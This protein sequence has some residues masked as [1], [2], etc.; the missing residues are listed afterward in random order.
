MRRSTTSWPKKAECG[1][2][3]PMKTEF[4]TIDEA[5][6][7]LRLGKRTTYELAR[8]GRLPGAVKVGG[9]WRVHR[10]QLLKWVQ[11]GGDRPQGRGPTRRGPYGV[12]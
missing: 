9:Q 3:A 2:T 7:L 5:A 8:N 4:L 6:L 11:E 1:I 10:Q 12:H